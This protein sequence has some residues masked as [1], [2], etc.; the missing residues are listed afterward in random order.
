MET[1]GVDEERA[2]WSTARVNNL[3]DSSFLYIEPGG[4]KDSGGK[5][6]PRSL[7]HFPVKDENGNVDMPH[8]R[9]ALSRIPQ[10][11]LPA[12]VKQECTAKAQKMMQ[13]QGRAMGMPCPECGAMNDMGAETCADCGASMTGRSRPELPTLERRTVPA[14]VE[15]R[16][17]TEGNLIFEGHAAVFDSWSS[18]LG[19]FREMIKPGAFRKAL[20]ANP[21][22][23]FLFNHNPDLVMARTTVPD[24]PGSLRLEEDGRGLRV[25]AELA[26][27]TAA[28]DLRTLAKAGVVDQMSFAFS[29]RDGGVDDWNSTYT[30]RTI[31]QFGA[32]ADVSPVT[33]PAY[34]ETTA[35]MRSQVC[36]ID[37]VT[38]QGEVQEDLLDALAKRI[39]RGSLIVS[40]EERSR[41]DAAFVKV[42]RLSPWVVEIARRTPGVGSAESLAPPADTEEMDGDATP[43]GQPNYRLAARKR[44]LRIKQLT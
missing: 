13:A 3:P 19:G 25:K 27:T 28:N 5:T 31:L 37:I 32:V 15:F 41:V 7:R 40:D 17:S 34:P 44:R 2:L 18:D 43:V 42:G 35:S 14:G 36:G 29:M 8:L 23:R 24:G 10:S 21:D 12:S 6:T 11:S 1:L 22:V 20:R 30:D 9:N 4:S 33:Y 39:H 16:D 38:S 26:P